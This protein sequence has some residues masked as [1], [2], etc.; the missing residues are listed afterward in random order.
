MA[1]VS[2]DATIAR[3][4][5]TQN[6]NVTTAQ[7]RAAGL[8]FKAIERRQQRGS[9]IRRHQRV[10]AVGHVPESWL[11][12]AH[13]AWLAY[14][15]HSALS[16][17]TC[18]GALEVLPEPDGPIH[19]TRATYGAAHE[20]TVLHQADLGGDTWEGN[21]LVLTS[22]A[23][24]MLDLAATQPFR[25][26]ERAYNEAQ[27]LNLLAPV[28]LQRR[29]DTWAGRRGVAALRELLTNHGV[30]RSMLEDAFKA[31]LREAG[32]PAPRFN[33]WVDGVFV[34][35][36]WLEQRVVVELDSRTYHGTDARFDTDRSKSN[37]LQLRGW[38]TLR[39][40]YGHLTK[41]RLWVV[42]SLSQALS[43]RLLVAA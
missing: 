4:A 7:L 18:A 21:G 19:V 23:R 24:L 38:L 39:F 9:L 11:S 40:T 33:Q 28:Q 35:A 20:G 34:D 14:G 12:R 31:L 2:P 25:V 16:H 5:S 42:A 36:A 3:L 22:P 43:R 27:V 41:R 37:D 17:T 29:V 26:L 8:S 6:G 32:L 30:T 13:A 15:E 10:Y 1:S